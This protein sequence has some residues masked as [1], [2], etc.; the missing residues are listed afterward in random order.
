[1][2]S[3]SDHIEPLV[4]KEGGYK[5]TDIAGDRGGKTYA[6]ISH[7]SHPGWEG[8]KLLER[9]AEPTVLHASVHKLYETDYWAPIKGDLLEDDG[10]AEIMFSCAVLSGPARAVRLAQQVCEVDVDGRM[11]PRTLEAD[12]RL[13][14]N[15]LFEARFALTRLHRFWEICERKPSHRKF[16]HGCNRRVFEELLK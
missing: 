13:S 12:E 10:K 1:M 14:T 15:D 6:G 16:D 11:G 2:A 7:R 4:R 5:L 3:F 9:G 8:W